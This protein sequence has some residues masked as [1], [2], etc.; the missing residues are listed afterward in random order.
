MR[1][2]S[3]NNDNRVYEG[4][5][6]RPDNKAIKRSEAKER[7]E[8]WQKLSPVQQLKALD[9]R[10]G[11]GKGATKQRARLAAQIDRAKNK[12]VQE[13][14][15]PMPEASSGGERIKAKDRRAQERAERPNK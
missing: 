3:K 1:A 8:A 2:N 12:P 9:T 10:F 11:A 4:G 13:D 7:T 6:P 5:G 15:A 14:R